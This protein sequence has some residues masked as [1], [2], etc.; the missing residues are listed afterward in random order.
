MATVPIDQC[1]GRFI[2]EGTELELASNA[3]VIVFADSRQPQG[4]A[5]RMPIWGEVLS[6]PGEII[7]RMMDN[8]LREE[9][10]SRYAQTAA[11]LAEPN[12]RQLGEGEWYADLVG[13]PGPWATGQTPWDALG[14]FKEVVQD[15][16]SLKLSSGDRDVPPLADLDL[17]TLL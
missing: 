11:S 7:E 15:W 9:L 16:A 1:T 3:C 13:L 6:Q 10:L 12:V 17:T 4:N 14:N 8:D 5:H 2:Q